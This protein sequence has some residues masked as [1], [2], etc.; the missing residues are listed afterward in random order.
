MTKDE[1]KEYICK[2]IDLMDTEDIY[3]LSYFLEEKDT[4]EALFGELT[5]IKG[6]FKKLT[7]L[8]QLTDTKIETIRHE[9]N[10]E[11]FKAFIT[12][13]SFLKN[14]KDALSSMPENSIFGISKFNRAFG[15]FENGFKSIDKL[16]G[17]ILDTLE[18]KLS[19]KIGDIFNPD[20]HEAVEVIEDKKVAD[21]TIV[22]IL[23]EGFLYKD[24]LLN[25]AKVKVN[26][27]TS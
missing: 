2:Q 26:K 11:D 15:S 17:N 27:W 21:G 8:V 13:Y 14:S 7:K 5:V 24:R 12:L 23:D 9:L 6:E 22:E 16:Y 20:F 25:Y 19:A 1:L 18:L 4:E 3:D 10:K